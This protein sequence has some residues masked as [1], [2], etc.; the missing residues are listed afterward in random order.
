MRHIRHTILLITLFI[1]F[2]LVSLP[3]YAADA[4]VSTCD[5]ASLSSAIATANAGGGIITFTCGGII[6]FTSEFTITANVTINGNGNN[7]ILWGVFAT[8]LFIVNSG[9]TLTLNGVQVHNGSSPSGGAIENNGTL[10]IISTRFLDSSSASSAGGAIYNNGTLTIVDSIF[11][12][13]S[14]F[15]GGAIYN[16]NILNITNTRFLSN[17]GTDGGAI[18]NQTTGTVII[19]TSYFENNQFGG[20]AIFN[21]GVASSQNTH[22]ATSSCTQNAVTDNGGNTNVSSAGC[23]GVAPIGLDVSALACSGNDATFTINFGDANFDVTGTGPNLPALNVPIS[24]V[25][26]SGAGSWT[27][28]TVTERLGD[29][30]SVNLGDIACPITVPLSASATCIGADL[31]VTISAGDANFQITAD[32]GTLITSVGVGTHTITGPVNVTNVNVTEFGGN[33]ENFALGD[34]NCFAS[35]T[36]TATATCNG[37]DL[38]VMITNG[39]APFTVNVTNTSGVL[40]LGGVA[41]GTYG[42][43]GPDTFANISVVEESGDLEVLN[44]PDVT[45]TAPVVPPVV[46]P[47]APTVILPPDINAL[48]C[49]LTSSIDLANA[50]DNTYCRILMKNGG[51]VSYSGAIPADLISLGVILAVD[52]YR[53]EGGATVNTFPDYARICLA[54]QGRLF[55]LDAR[56]SPRTQVELATEIVNGMTCGWIPAAGTLVLTN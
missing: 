16:G 14:S 8:D 55:Y 7:V 3:A 45:C 32:S 11:E 1:V 12:L 5:L 4:T 41:L 44:L 10:N 37:A 33:S 56:T 19:N 17:T 50:P 6:S 23:P 52:M 13:N 40:S 2:S 47:V 18:Y 27:G 49:E 38:E 51:V 15:S 34:F 42:F 22:F 25:T 39:N 20:G 21:R 46:P 29:R 9:A 54:G 31:Q 36:L 30:Q 24:S 26:L 53:L 28:V 35:S 48:G 43:T